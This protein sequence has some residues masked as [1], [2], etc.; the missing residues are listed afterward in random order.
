MNDST[1]GRLRAAKYMSAVARLLSG[2]D[3]YPRFIGKVNV[4]LG[5][6]PINLM[7]LMH[8]GGHVRA[9]G[10]PIIHFS[11]SGE[12]SLPTVSLVAETNGRLHVIEM[13]M[14]WMGPADRRA[15]L[16]PDSFKMGAFALDD[17]LTLR[18]L[19]R[20][21]ARSFKAGEPGMI[22]AYDRLAELV[23]EQLERDQALPMP[24][25]LKAA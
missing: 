16:V 9:G 20:A 14:L 7:N 12:H 22:R 18:H 5:G 21:P 8:W 10:R 15:Q 24:E 1:S 4:M 13:C 6:A 17:R 11:M 23:A 25:L 19:T 3:A 2:D